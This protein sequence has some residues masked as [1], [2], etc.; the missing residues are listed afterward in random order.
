MRAVFRS[1]PGALAP[2]GLC[3]PGHLRL[4]GPMRPTR[5][6]IPTSPHSRFIRD[7]LAVPIGIGLGSP[8]VVLSFH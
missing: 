5:R 1:T 6:R 7:A 8:R 2:A 3:C 4:T